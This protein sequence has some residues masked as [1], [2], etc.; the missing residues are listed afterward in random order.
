MPLAAIMIKIFY[1][2]DFREWYIFFRDQK[3]KFQV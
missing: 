3:K 1:D 2:N